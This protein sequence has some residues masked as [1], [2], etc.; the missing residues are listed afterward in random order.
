M[1]QADIFELSSQ[2][3]LPIEMKELLYFRAR[4]SSFSPLS[5]CVLLDHFNN[6]IARV[7]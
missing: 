1:E 5:P 3:R 6:Q 2:L 4:Y 7:S